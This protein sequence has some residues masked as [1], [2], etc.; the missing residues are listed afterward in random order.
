MPLG[1]GFRFPPWRLQASADVHEPFS[2]WSVGWCDVRSDFRFCSNGPRAA[3]A[4]AED[5]RVG[6]V[7]PRPTSPSDTLYP[8]AYTSTRIRYRLPTRASYHFLLLARLG[9]RTGT[10]RCHVHSLT[11]NLISPQWQL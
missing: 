7:R 3:S 1:T 11:K 6:Q 5:P 10:G 4:E 8:T 2:G 9:D